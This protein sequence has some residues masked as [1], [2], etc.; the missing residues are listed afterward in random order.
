MFKNIT[1]RVFMI[2]DRV[3]NIVSTDNH[4]VQMIINRMYDI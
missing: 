3:G 2:L 4:N 1:G